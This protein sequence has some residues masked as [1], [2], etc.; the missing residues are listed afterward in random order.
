MD[1][2]GLD[3]KIIRNIIYNMNYI[4]KN[5]DKIILIGFMIALPA[6]SLANTVYPTNPSS[7]SKTIVNPIHSETI[8]DLIQ[9]IL[10][11]LI[12]IGMPVIVLAIIYCGFLFVSAQGNSEKLNEAKR[13]LIYT[14]IGAAIFLGAYAISILISSTVSAL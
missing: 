7:S 1:G 5:F 3:F 11:G 14:L 12:K 4:K 2:I 6:I 8:T 9:T 13:A 10:K